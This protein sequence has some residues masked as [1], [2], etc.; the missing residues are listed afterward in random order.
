MPI[1]AIACMA[2]PDRACTG[3]HCNGTCPATTAC[4]FPLEDFGP[5]GDQF[6]PKEYGLGCI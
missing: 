4:E 2:G 5:E 6:P 3:T 1:C